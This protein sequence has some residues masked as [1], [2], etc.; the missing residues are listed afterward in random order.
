MIARTDR[1]TLQ[2]VGDNARLL[3]SR[4]A[5]QERDHV[6][7]M[8]PAGEPSGVAEAWVFRA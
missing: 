5:T 6:D 7:P 8:V 2:F 1:S 3:C 4:G